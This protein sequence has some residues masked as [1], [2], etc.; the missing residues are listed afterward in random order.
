MTSAGGDVEAGDHHDAGL[1][2]VDPVLQPCR[3]Y[4][5][6]LQ[7]LQGVHLECLPQVDCE[8]K[9]SE[10]MKYTNTFPRFL[11]QVLFLHLF[12]YL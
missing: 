1:A 12:I 5:K 11:S 9:D 8:T 7:M 10:T 2:D 4:L 6:G 3:H